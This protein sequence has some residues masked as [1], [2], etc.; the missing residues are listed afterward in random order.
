M[1]SPPLATLDT[2]RHNLPLQPTLL[3]G[4]EREVAAVAA[5]LRRTEVRLLALT[6]PGGTGKTRLGLQAAAE[7][8]EDFPDG[9][10]IVPLAALA[11]PSLVPAAIA[12]ALEVRGSGNTPLRELLKS[13]R[14]GKQTLLLLDNFEHL[15]EAASE[16][17]DLLSGCLRLKS[18]V[19]SRVPL[20][21]RAEHV[22]SD[23]P[24]ALPRRKPPPTPEQLTQY[25]K[26][27]VPWGRSDM[28]D[29]CSRESCTPGAIT[30]VGTY[31]AEY[32]GARLTNRGLHGQQ[33]ARTRPRHDA[34]TR[35]SHRR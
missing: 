26:V 23:T 10:F 21:V 8:L 22:F 16:L 2:R 11:D 1:R 24:L 20:H 31:D 9:V 13:E 3:M 25:E 6:G 28:L 5:L 30:G 29:S 12:E 4:R 27:T 19:S 34:T 7:L 17:T 33:P 14:A 32:L 18:L 15:P 35:L